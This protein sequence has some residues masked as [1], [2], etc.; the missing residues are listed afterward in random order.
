M[1]FLT[2]AM[3]V[4]CGRVAEEYFSGRELAQ[5]DQSPSETEFP[6]EQ[7]QLYACTLCRCSRGCRVQR[8]LRTQKN[9]SQKQIEIYE[10]RYDQFSINAF[11][12]ALL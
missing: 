6:S 8:V 9:V 10:K 4:L 12:L 2:E 1:L 7:E 11:D 5:N 3:Y